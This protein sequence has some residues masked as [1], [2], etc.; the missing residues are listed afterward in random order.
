MKKP[1]PMTHVID[2]GYFYYFRYLCVL[3]QETLNTLF[4]CLLKLLLM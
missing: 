4:R 1:L 2:K 3:I